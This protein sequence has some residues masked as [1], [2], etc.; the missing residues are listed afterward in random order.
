MNKDKIN[1]YFQNL[2]VDYLYHLGIDTGM[3]LYREFNDVKYVI[4]TLS[5]AEAKIIVNSFARSIYNIPN[6][7]FTYNPIYK[8]ERFHMYKVGVTIVISGGVGIQSLLICINEI[9][10]LL[11]HLKKY[12]VC[13][14]KI[15]LSATIGKQSGDVILS[16]NIVN[17]DFNNIFYSI[18]CGVIQEYPT[19]LEAKTAKELLA[20]SYTQGF[21]N[22]SIGT[23]LSAHNFGDMQT[24]M[25]DARVS[26]AKLLSENSF[27]NNAYNIGVRSI[28][29]ESLSFAGF[30]AW[31][32]IPACVI[33]ISIVDFLIK[34]D[35]S[36]TMDSQ[37][38]MLSRFAPILNGYI[39]N[40]SKN[41]LKEPVPQNLIKKNESK[42]Y[43][44]HSGS[45]I[46]YSY[47]YNLNLS[48]N[49]KII[50][51]FKGIKYVFMQGSSFRAKSLAKKFAKVSFGIEEEYF[52]PQNLFP[53]AFFEGYRVG[54]ALSVSHGM[55][56]MSV[57]SLLYDI[58][59]LMQACNNKDLQYIRLG[60]S[61]G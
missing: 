52:I 26:G 29:M 2:P 7:N 50:D 61:G 39:Q 44:N 25:K 20:Y 42:I 14:F 10:K 34:A 9:T 38:K 58:T 36:A 12:D 1:P 24:I 4:F 59:R 48:L 28:D 8:M 60:T 18:Q 54:N 21:N 31:L 53:N 3:D 5:N 27:L 6:E 57:I 47:L 17:S 30:C 41:I 11:I 15:G 45:N 51:M 56:A 49:S 13:Y 55:G 46:K 32:E 22:I 16:N 23:N 19:I 40:C 43:Q 37:L 35:A 33:D